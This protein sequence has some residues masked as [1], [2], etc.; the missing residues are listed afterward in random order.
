[1]ARAWVPV[2]PTGSIRK[3][4]EGVEKVDTYQRVWTTVV[5]LVGVLA[6][7]VAIQRFGG[8]A[9]VSLYVLS[10]ALVAALTVA[11]ERRGTPVTARAAAQSGAV[12]GAVALA[13]FGTVFVL[14][15]AGVLVLLAGALSSPPVLRS[16]MRR[17][18]DGNG[19]V[20]AAGTAG[21]GSPVHG[22]DP[23]TDPE[24]DADG[25]PG[26][27][28]AVEDL[29]APESMSDAD[30]HLAWRRS[31]DALQRA[32]SV[33]DQLLVVQ[34]RQRYLDEL[35]RRHPSGLSGWLA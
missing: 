2:L 21:A 20:G 8:T 19:H 4:R 15:P 9:A 28:V 23:V 32:V 13:A 31:Y 5:A 30:L 22:A 27:T 33:T 17:G 26:T 1:M 6:L 25:A 11:L 35:E 16:L 7:L 18:G 29:A 24:T 3:A 14:G 10:G 34:R 12:G